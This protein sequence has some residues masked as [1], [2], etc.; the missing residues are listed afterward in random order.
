MLAILNDFAAAA[1]ARL[2]SLKWRL[3]LAS[4][5][6]IGL[7]VGSTA[8]L[9][10]G[11]SDQRAERSILE[12][13][14]G[15]DTVGQTLG[16][17]LLHREL[18][19]AHAGRAWPADRTLTE[20]DAAGFL[21]GQAVLATLFSRLWLVDANGALLAE[22]E[23]AAVH[24]RTANLADRAF[25]K[26][27][28]QAGGSTV[29]VEPGLFGRLQ[30]VVSVPLP[31]RRRT[32]APGVA[33]L[34]G[35]LDA[36]SDSLFTDV[37]GRDAGGDDPIGTIVTDASGRIIAHPDPR[38]L[39]HDA[40]EEPRLRDAVA[41][42]RAQGAPLEASAWTWHV[43]PQFVALAAVPQA[44]WM[45][46]RTASAGLLLGDPAK[47]RH[48]AWGLSAV[49]ALVGAGLIAALCNR[50]LRPM[51]ELE[52]RALLL[53][54][55]SLPPD[56]QWPKATGEIGH[57]SEVLQHVL[58]LRA[59]SRRRSEELLVR[60]RA[61][62]RHAPVGIGFVR[63]GRIELVSRRLSETLGYAGDELVGQ[64]LAALLPDAAQHD[65]LI[66]AAQAAFARA[67]SYRAE[68][69]LR[70]RDGHTLWAYLQGAALA[71]EN[72]QDGTIWILSD[73]SELRAQRDQLRWSASHDSLTRLYNR[74]E[75]VQRLDLVCK[76]SRRVESSCLVMVDLDGFKAV[77]DAA[78]HP[79]GDA[80]LQD[81]A[82]LL[83]GQVRDSDT[84]ARL[85]GD[86]FALLLH[87][88]ELARAT[89]IAE[90]IRASV[91]AHRR[92]WKGRALQV[93][94]SIGVIHLSSRYADAERALAAVDA[95]CYAAKRQG[96]N[97]VSVGGRQV[98]GAAP[99]LS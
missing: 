86:E 67:R 79:A 56:A 22:A 28:L 36:D 18:A 7:S 6:V 81:V 72:P 57:L 19:L 71:P 88:C 58:A 64:P 53:L 94:A 24:A 69:Q 77:N 35:L 30:I 5:S 25:F 73:I 75:L 74:R 60:M 4:I 99:A 61:L 87:G 3:A 89:A 38:W 14:L 40:G 16:S 26:R 85:G 43:G 29:S 11:G 51:T 10:I 68:H 54:D 47:A 93:G 15:V 80:V 76:N 42:W 62:M 65:T 31:V 97:R 49:V 13:R 78:G 8:V 37:I 45:V 83:V 2:G 84:V 82:E 50:L 39:Q 9:V 41:R 59:A 96:R 32:G 34:C 17:R 55:E 48:E 92:D 46:F 52:R 98:A 66:A 1:R 44:D 33:V 90:K 21:R 91:A 95:A 12:S 23:G 20:A 63:D 27:A 70:H